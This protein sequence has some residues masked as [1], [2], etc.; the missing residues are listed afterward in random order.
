MHNSMES[1]NGFETLVLT[2]SQLESALF[3]LEDGRVALFY[4]SPDVMLM[5][6]YSDDAGRTW[7]EGRRW[8]TEDGWAIVGLR[9]NPVRP[10][11]GI[12]GMLHTDVHQR[13]GRDG[14]LRFRSSDNECETWSH[15]SLVDPYFAVARVNT[16][17]VLSSGRIVA[18]VMRWI[19][20]AAGGES[21]MANRS[22]CYSWVKYS[23]DEGQTW[24][25]SLSELFVMLDE[26]RAGAYSLEEPAVEEL[27]D[28][29]ILMLG[30]TELGRQYRSISK[31]GGV[32]WSPPE[33]T[34]I[35][36]SYTPLHLVRIP[37]T[38]D[39]MIIWN[40]SSPEEIESGLSRAR[41]TAAISTDDGM[42]W[43][44]HRNLESPDD[45]VRIP[46][47]PIRV[48]R[49]GEY[50]KVETGRYLGDAVIRRICYPSVAFLGDEVLVCYDFDTPDGHATKLRVLPL[51]WFYQ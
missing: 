25:D 37:K 29:S 48:Y 1:D 21:E 41:L 33:P 30:R 36:C 11:S 34:E 40:Q 46:A 28:G 32:T 44:H 51:D 43:T 42:T 39:L 31:D 45:T 27:K 4:M 15:G 12:V 17:R 3:T 13:S 20:C 7:S 9:P 24:N 10:R 47:P 16:A 8:L 18:P 6:K 38:G 49:R 22:F 50:G 35:A 23:D 2:P 5:W 19:S 14:A 26:G